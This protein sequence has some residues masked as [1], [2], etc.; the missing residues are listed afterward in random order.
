MRFLAGSVPSPSVDKLENR[1]KIGEEEDDEGCGEAWGDVFGASLDPKEAKRARREE[2]EYVPNMKLYEKV[3]IGE[4]YAQTGKGPISVRWI[5]INK[6]DVESPNYRFRFVA[7]GITTSKRND[8][9]AAT[10]P[11][12][13]LKVILSIASSGNKG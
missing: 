8:C 4:A 10:P 3:P 9:V 12:E 6:G 2:I 7:R 5:D 1:F 13:A 11:L